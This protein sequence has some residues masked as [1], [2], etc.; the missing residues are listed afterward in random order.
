[1]S[2]DCAVCVIRDGRKFL[3]TQRKDDDRF[4]GFWEFPGGKRETGETLEACALREAREEIG[5]DVRIES[6][7]VKVENPYP[8][9]P[10]T[11][12]FFLCAAG[13][14]PIAPIECRAIRWVDVLELGEYLFPPANEPVISLL[15][16]R[17]SVGRN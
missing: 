17:F 9:R 4:G 8:D 13:G 15:V 3:I 6:F 12:H 5:A 10:L 1:M 7:L 11:L 16:E 14:G 2:T